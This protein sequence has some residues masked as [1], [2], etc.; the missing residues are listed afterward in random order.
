MCHRLAVFRLLSYFY[1]SNPVLIKSSLRKQVLDDVPQHDLMLVMGDLNAKVGTAQ[2]DEERTVGNHSIKGVRNDNGER[3]VA[4]CAENNL[5]IS[6]TMFPHKEI[7]KYTWTS[8]DGKHR[9]QIDHVAVNTRFKRSVQDAR[10]YRGADVGSDHNLVVAKTRLKL[11]STGKKQKGT[12]R[13]EE[14]KLKI[15][16]TREKYMLELRNRFSC[17]EQE[18]ETQT[19][20]QD[21]IEREW[22]K[23]KTAYN[24]SAKEILGY[25]KRKNQEWISPN[26]WK[27]IEERKKLKNKID[28]TRS[29]RI[30]DRLREQY[31]T[32][33]KEIKKSLRR[34]K[35]S[36]VNSIAQEAESAASQGQMKGVYDATRKLCNEGPRKVGTIKNKEGKVITKE[37]DIKERWREHFTEVLN[38][39]NPEITAN[40]EVTEQENQDIETGN[41]TR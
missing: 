35:R 25:R 19:T 28:S 40:I 24:E 21:V 16:E 11:N 22:N 31:R 12:T 15:K 23:I 27:E 8:P 36:W 6:T 7:H 5:A 14:S 39:P 30:K 13:Y 34:D 1:N 2:K 26:S 20:E 4:F 33:D 29:E 17:L 3:F 37:D 9:N 41:I 38:R 10:T 18:D 32:K